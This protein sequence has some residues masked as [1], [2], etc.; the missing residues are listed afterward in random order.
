[1][2]AFRKVI[3]GMILIVHFYSCHDTYTICDIDTNVFERTGFYHITSGVA[4]PAYPTSFT[5]Q[6]VGGTSPIFSNVGGTTRFLLALNPLIDSA[7]YQLFFYPN[8][9]PDTLSFYYSSQP[10]TVSPDCGSIYINTLNRVNI[11]RHHV[12]SAVISNNT[13]TNVSG[14]NLKIYL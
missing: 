14:E 10:Y 4:Q 2:G 5:L 8:S 6:M 3:V 9:S 7:K 13:V 12:D 1:M 11:T